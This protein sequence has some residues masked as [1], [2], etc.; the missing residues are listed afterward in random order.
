[1]LKKV[2]VRFYVRVFEKI[3]TLTRTKR[4]KCGKLPPNRLTTADNKVKIRESIE[5]EL[6]VLTSSASK[7]VTDLFI[8]V[9]QKGCCENGSYPFFLFVRR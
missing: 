1:M 8:A 7:E 5:A 6:S 3:R 2:T 9:R 4:V